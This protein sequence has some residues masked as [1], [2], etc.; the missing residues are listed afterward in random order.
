M[1]GEMFEIYFFHMA[2]NAFKFKLSTVVGKKFEIH[3]SRMAKNVLKL[4]TMVGEKN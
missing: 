2:E 1:L 4:S 3:S